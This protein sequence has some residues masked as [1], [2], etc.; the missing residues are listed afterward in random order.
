MTKAS[1]LLLN[2]IKTSLEQNCLTPRKLRHPLDTRITRSFTSDNFREPRSQHAF[3]GDETRLWNSA[4]NGIRKAKTISKA[5]K[6]I[7]TYCKS[8]PI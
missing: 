5:K 3:I 2:E 7:K 4:P 8:L 6:E 1:L